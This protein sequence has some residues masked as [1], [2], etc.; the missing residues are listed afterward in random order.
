MKCIILC[1]DNKNI[2]FNTNKNIP[3]TLM[4]VNDGK[5]IINYIIDSVKNENINEI[6]LV[7]NNTHYEALNNFM[8]DINVNKRISVVN[9]TTNNP[10]ERLGAMGDIQYVINYFDIKDDILVIF[11]DNIYDF[12]LNELI[13]NTINKNI[14]HIGIMKE[15]NLD[16]VKEFG[17][18]KV[19]TN[20]Q[21]IEFTEKPTNPQDNNISLGIYTLTKEA[22]PY[23]KFYLEEG[24]KVDAPG[25]FI[26]YLVNHKPILTYEFKGKF[27]D[28]NKEEDLNK[29]K[30]IF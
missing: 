20:N 14:A 7:S 12:S 26:K 8:K 16:K 19:G 6:I 10:N 3:R 23:I 17:V 21:V 9:D 2:N 18:V 4:K 28:V 1:S 27:V 11:G 25:Y 13:N 22:L 5:R 24:N 29:A 30:E 15:E